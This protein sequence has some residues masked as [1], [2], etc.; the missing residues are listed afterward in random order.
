MRRARQI[1]A[2]GGGGFSMEPRNPLLDRVERVDGE[3]RETVVVPRFL[4]S[5][6]DSAS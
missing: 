6:G 2:M 5:G 4:G 3:V 1:I